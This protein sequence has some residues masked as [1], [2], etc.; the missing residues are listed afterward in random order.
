MSVNQIKLFEAIIWECEERHWHV[1]SGKFNW[2]DD[3]DTWHISLT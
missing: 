1:I 2:N 3:Q